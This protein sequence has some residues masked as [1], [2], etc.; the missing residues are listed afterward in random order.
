MHNRRELAEIVQNL[1]LSD[2]FE[3][4]LKIYLTIA[5]RKGLACARAYNE[6]PPPASLMVQ[7]SLFTFLILSIMPMHPMAIPA[8]LGGGLSMALLVESIRFLSHY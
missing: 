5:K 7:A 4:L 1:S 6:L 2:Q 8:S 3:L